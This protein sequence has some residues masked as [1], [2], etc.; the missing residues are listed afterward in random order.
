MVSEFCEKYGLTPE[1]GFAIKGEMVAQLRANELAVDELEFPEHDSSVP[2][3][4]V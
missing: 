3:P 4:E 2:K 1:V